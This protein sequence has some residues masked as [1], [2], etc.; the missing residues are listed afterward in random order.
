MRGSYGIHIIYYMSDVT[1]GEVALDEIRDGVTELALSDK[2]KST[3]ENQ[4]DAWIAEANV[5]YF[6]SN[7]GIA[8]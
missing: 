1:P 7:F 4:V 3:Y 8:G 2:I 5:E 6:Y